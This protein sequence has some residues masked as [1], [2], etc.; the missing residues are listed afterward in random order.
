[1]LLAGAKRRRRSADHERVFF[2]LAG[3]CLR[4]GY[5]YPLDDWRA[6]EA[7]ALLDEGLQHGRQAQVWA[8][9]WTFWRR[10]A[11]GLDEATQL[12]LW[13]SLE[14]HFPGRGGKAPASA[15]ASAS[16]A[17]PK[18][19]TLP[20]MIR[21]AAALERVPPRRKAALGDALL[22]SAERT[23]LVWWAIGRLGAR[24]PLHGS[25]HA[26]V[27]RATAQAWLMAAL[28]ADWERED[29]AAF[30]AALLGRRTG[31]RERDVDDALRARLL[32]RLAGPRWPASWSRM[33]D[34]VASLDETDQRLVF[35]E[36]LPPG[37]R[38]IEDRV[39]EPES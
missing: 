22:A 37:L 13:E 38:L 14:P 29:G 30:A 1:V 16:S 15:P 24:A 5:G 20:E 31:D 17:G 28:D 32:A 35:G 34:H 26:V 8:E 21:L 12:R 9:W 25:A 4:P 2:S 6:R 27:P 7:A 10:V 33:A 19:S 23:P 18:A 36:S 11:G 39:V 3:W